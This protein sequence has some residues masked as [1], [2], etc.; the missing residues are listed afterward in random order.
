[1]IGV[2][3][4]GRGCLAG[5]V[6]AAACIPSESHPFSHF[7]DS[8]KL[9]PKRRDVLSQEIQLNHRVSVGGASVEEIDSLNILRASLLAMKRAVEG[10]GVETGH[11]IV[12]GTFKVPGL[13]LS[14]Q[15]TTLTKGDLRAAPVAAASIVAKVTRDNVLQELEAVY[16]GYGFAKHKGYSTRLHKEAIV[17]LGPTAVHRKSFAGVKEHLS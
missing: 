6:Y 3:E 10:L 11:L 4:V 15:Q 7:T 8:K 16:P 5:D 1:M 13:P 14:F 12:D 17:R 2:D 9:S